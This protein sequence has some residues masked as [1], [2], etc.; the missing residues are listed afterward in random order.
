MLPFVACIYIYNYVSGS[1]KTQTLL[2]SNVIEISPQGLKFCNSVEKIISYF[3][4]G[5]NVWIYLNHS[6]MYIQTH[7]CMG[8]YL[9]DYLP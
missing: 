6:H 9:R 4:D 1:S 5:N 7:M 2:P 3:I 8:P